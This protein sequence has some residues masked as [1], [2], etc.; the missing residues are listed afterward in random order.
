MPW[1]DSD[2]SGGKVRLKHSASPG[3]TIGASGL[4]PGEIAVNT[5]DGVIYHKHPTGIV[6]KIPGGITDTIAFLDGNSNTIEIYITN[7][8]ITGWLVS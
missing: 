6:Q 3:E 8:L 1:Q 2:V 7:G 4:V 5:A